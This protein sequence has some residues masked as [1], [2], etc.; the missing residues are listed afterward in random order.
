MKEAA[1]VNGRQYGVVVT[2][3]VA[4]NWYVKSPRSHRCGRAGSR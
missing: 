4:E 1:S 2:I 3:N